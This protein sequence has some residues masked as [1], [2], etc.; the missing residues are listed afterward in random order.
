V[1][2]GVVVVVVPGVGPAKA[3]LATAKTSP[4]ARIERAACVFITSP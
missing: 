2:P 3:A 1:V 4:M